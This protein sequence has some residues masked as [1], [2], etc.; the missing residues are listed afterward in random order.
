MGVSNSV[1]QPLTW[2]GLI[3]WE[4]KE[5]LCLLFGW[6]SSALVPCSC[7]SSALFSL[8]FLALRMLLL[9]VLFSFF[10]W[11]FLVA[12]YCCSLAL[13]ESSAL[14]LCLWH[15]AKALPYA[16]ALALS[17]SSAL[18]FCPLALS[19]SSALILLFALAIK[20]K[21]LLITLYIFCP[22]S[23]KKSENNYQ[24]QRK[25]IINSILFY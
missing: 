10:P 15:W 25:F 21:L 13:S 22:F 11:A 19:K 5:E 18:F 1:S 17:E 24:K 20:D 9:L 6:A 23:A 4:K 8:L 12:F 14:V 7:M 2:L 3:K 16:F